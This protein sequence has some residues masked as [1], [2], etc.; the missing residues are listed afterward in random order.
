M[1]PIC[2]HCEEHRYAALWL[3]H[4]HTRAVQPHCGYQGQTISATQCCCRPP[5]P[6]HC[7]WEWF[8][9]TGQ[10]TSLVNRKSMAQA[11]RGSPHVTKILSLFLISPSSSPLRLV[12]GNNR[13]CNRYCKW[14]WFTHY[15]P[16]SAVKS[17]VRLCYSG[18]QEGSLAEDNVK[19]AIKRRYVGTDLRNIS[20]YMPDNVLTTSHII[21][22]KQ[23]LTNHV[24]VTHITIGR[25]GS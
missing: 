21:E 5:P 18:F 3:S 9:T 13:K 16:L 17:S 7:D 24:A 11:V 4:C 2:K 23:F 6:W 1:A 14:A 8:L 25:A 19:T 20:G 12:N 15:Y 22:T 10:T